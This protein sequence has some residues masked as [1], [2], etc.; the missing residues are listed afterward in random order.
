[1]MKFKADFIDRS[2]RYGLSLRHALNVYGN[3]N[4]FGRLWGKAADLLH[5]HVFPD[6]L[7]HIKDEVQEDFIY[8]AP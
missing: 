1:M 8:N 4:T 3:Y 6:V 7:D 2:A 5:D